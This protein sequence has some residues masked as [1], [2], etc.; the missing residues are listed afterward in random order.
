VSSPAVTKDEEK[1]KIKEKRERE[2]NRSKR[3]RS[4][5]SACPRRSVDNTGGTGDPASR[6]ATRARVNPNRGLGAQ[7]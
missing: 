6:Q 2:R 4:S 5:R 7:P 1:R 3:R